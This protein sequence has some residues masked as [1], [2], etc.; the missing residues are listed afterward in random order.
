[1]RR[2]VKNTVAIVVVVLGA[3]AASTAL[4]AAVEDENAAQADRALT[5]ALAKA[6]KTAAGKLLDADFEWTDASGRAHKKAD[7][8]EDPGALASDNQDDAKVDTHNY[9][10]VE[11]VVGVHHNAHFVRLWVKRPAGWR[12]LIFLDTPIPAKGYANH[13]SPPRPQDKDCVNPCKM[14]P[15]KPT[16]PGEQAAVDTWLKLKI[17][18]WHAIPD[19]WQMRV[20]DSMVV[21]SPTMSFDKAGRLGLLIKQKE[22]YGDGSPSAPVVSMRMFDFGDAVI[23]TAL[24]GPNAAGKPSYAVRIFVNEGGTWKI[25]LSAQTDIAV[26]ASTARLK[27]TQ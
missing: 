26:P 17:D 7:V 11:R 24:H 27:E 25:A 15:Y 23:M 5:A 13:P 10:R 21:I 2:S 6:D 16:S 19:D 18:E 3:I 22:A 14:L 8:V 1:M 9:G 4:R 20:S 12:A